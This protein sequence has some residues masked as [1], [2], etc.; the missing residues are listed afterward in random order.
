MESS[1][2]PPNSSSLAD[3]RK[4]GIGPLEDQVPQLVLMIRSARKASGTKSRGDEHKQK[5]VMKHEEAQRAMLY[6]LVAG[7]VYIVVDFGKV[8]NATWAT[9]LFDLREL[10]LAILGK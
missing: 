6:T 8:G 7:G 2:S 9:S 5:D 1:S 10:R 4:R 3:F